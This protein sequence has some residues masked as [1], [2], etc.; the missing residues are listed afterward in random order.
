VKREY[1]LIVARPG[2]HRSKAA[3]VMDNLPDDCECQP[4]SNPIDQIVNNYSSFSNTR[5]IKRRRAKHLLIACLV[6]F[7][8]VAL[9]VSRCIVLHRSHSHVPPPNDLAAAITSYSTETRSFFDA[10]TN[11]LVTFILLTYL[12]RTFARPKVVLYLVACLFPGFTRWN[13][14]QVIGRQKCGCFS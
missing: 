4:I 14:Y 5:R 8:L 13:Y 7:V 3:H 1:A 12:F 2:E 9:F 6:I 11:S 10:S